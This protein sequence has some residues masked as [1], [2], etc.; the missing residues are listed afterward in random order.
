MRKQLL[1]GSDWSLS[2]WSRHQWHYERSMELGNSSVPVVS[3]IAAS[4]PG[5][6]QTDLLRAGRI[7]DWN[8]GDNFRKIEWLEHREW[9]YTKNFIALTAS[10]KIILHLD[11]LDFSGYVF[12]NG[13]QVYYFDKM[14][15]PHC[16]DVTKVIKPNAENTLKI[17]FLQPPEVDGQVGYTSKVSTLKS[18]FNYGWDW[19]P[20]LVNI[21]IFRDVWLE[22]ADMISVKK[23]YPRT[24][25]HCGEG[26]LEA[27]VHITAF[28]DAELK[29]K[30]TLKKSGEQIAESECTFSI[31]KGERE[32]VFML[33][34]GAI[35]PWFPNGFGSQPLYEAELELCDMQGRRL[36]QNIAN[37]GFKSLSYTAPENAPEG[38]LAYNAVINGRIIPIRGIN[39]VPVLP[40]YG[41]VTEEQYRFYLNRFK[42]MGCN[43]IRVW[44][45][46]LQESETFYNICDEMGLMVWQEF[47]QSSSGIDNAP[48]EDPAYLAEL[49]E[50]AVE[51]TRRARNHVCLTYWCGGNELYWGENF[52][53]AD[54]SSA[55]LS[56]LEGVVERHMPGVMY[57][58]SSPSHLEN[59]VKYY[60]GITDWVN[61][62]CHGSWLYEGI[63]SHYDMIYNS[64]SVLFSEIGSPACARPEKLTEYCTNGKVWPPDFSN[65][66]WTDRGAW[67]ILYEPLK[68]LFGDF[69]GFGENKLSKYAA[70]FRFLQAESLRSSVCAVRRFG[71]KKSG[72]IFWMGNEPFPNTANTSLLEMDGYTKPAYYAV[73]KG[74]GNITAGLYYK[75]PWLK[76]SHST[77]AQLFIC[78]D[79]PET[80]DNIKLTVF[81]EKGEL[82][83]QKI[84]ENT[85]VS[86]TVELGD[87]E[88][89]VKES[90][91]L[92]RLEISGNIFD[93]WVFTRGKEAFRPLLTAPAAELECEILPDNR[94]RITNTG[95]IT[96]YYVE[97]DA[98]TADKI[99]VALD[100]GYFC[101]LPSESRVCSAE[102]GVARL[103]AVSMN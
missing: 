14:M 79:N 69:E 76:D 58:P 39:W 19:S 78:S 4:V 74:F 16:V 63:S 51:Y 9:V 84:W 53:P 66:Y 35:E 64:S 60:E 34:A 59:G 22:Y 55:N 21:G 1:N 45:G 72:I 42:C 103:N 27:M 93:E 18:R 32:A 67:W 100:N 48:N 49:K 26:H 17:V 61:G 73:K 85:A 6:V 24:E 82:I 37:V 102:R 29:A 99:P 20:R 13:E 3:P 92:V 98:I 31:L 71:N 11:G 91:S 44:G 23:F 75:T 56:M 38:C 96:A 36:S 5:S 77:K 12:L 83:S 80:V 41:A 28:R 46:A 62:D 88:I 15:L 7:E 30:L 40:F 101:L 97:V 47:P 33:K 50:V 8:Y 43:L 70:A 2:G 68:K 25:L 95:K 87:I 57:L 65:P 81:D 89:E 90:I 10:D 86:G 94:V 52:F 54:T